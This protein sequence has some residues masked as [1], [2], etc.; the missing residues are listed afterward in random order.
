VPAN[1]A[2]LADASA[3]PPALS[4]ARANADAL[5]TTEAIAIPLPQHNSL[6][7]T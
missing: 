3:G 5:L 2:P 4:V 1:A 7:Q 6:S